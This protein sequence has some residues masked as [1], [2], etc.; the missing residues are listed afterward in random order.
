MCNF[1]EED[2]NT[3][4]IDE[5]RKCNRMWLSLI[6]KQRERNLELIRS[7]ISSLQDELSF[8]TDIGNFN[9]WDNNVNEQMMSFEADLIRISLINLKEIDSIIYKE[10][11]STGGSQYRTTNH[12]ISTGNLEWVGLYG[13]LPQKGEQQLIKGGKPAPR[14]N[15]NNNN[16]LKIFIILQGLLIMSTIH[17]IALTLRSEACI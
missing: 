17:V 13:H 14:G 8:F 9:E 15:N 5:L 7:T 1:I 2:L 16:H 12:P 11:I 3:E 4:W 10:G 6:I